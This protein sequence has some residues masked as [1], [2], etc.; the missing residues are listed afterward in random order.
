MCADRA[1][2]LGDDLTALLDKAKA[3]YDTPVSPVTQRRLD[4][5]ADD[6]NTLDPQRLSPIPREPDA[7]DDAMSSPGFTI[8]DSDDDDDEEL[9]Q[10]GSTS[11]SPTPTANGENRSRS[12]MPHLE[13]P[14]SAM[15]DEDSPRS[16][17]ESQ[18]RSLTL[19]EGEVFR[20]G[21][22]LGTGEVDEDDDEGKGDVSGEELKK[23]VSCSVSDH[24]N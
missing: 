19:E 16:P 14:E 12:K 20:K 21:A 13:I 1:L 9:S 18:S 10:P 7:P 15:C 11:S 17:M 3:L 22:V 5:N 24:W 8:A 6:S 4:D 23:E 2:R